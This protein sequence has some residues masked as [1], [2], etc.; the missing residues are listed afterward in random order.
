M[1]NIINKSM[2]SAAISTVIMLSMTSTYAATGYMSFLSTPVPV[3]TGD[4]ASYM[5]VGRDW[6]SSTINGGIASPNK[7]Q[8]STITTSKI[9][10]KL[11]L[12]FKIPDR[13]MVNTNPATATLSC[14]D[15]VIVQIRPTNTSQASTLRPG[16]G[17]TTGDIN[18][19]Y[20]YMVTIKN[21]SIINP[22]DLG[23][24]PTATNLPTLYLPN[25]SGSN[26]KSAATS[27]SATVT[28]NGPTLGSGDKYDFTLEIPLSEIGNPTSDIG[29]SLAI[30]NDLGHAH[31]NAG[32]TVEEITGTAFP[33]SMGMTS[34]SDPGI[35]CAG[36]AIILNDPIATGNW[37][38]PNTWGTAFV[39]PP[40]VADV[41]FDHTPNVN[42]SSAIRLGNCDADWSR[43]IPIPP[44]EDWVAWQQNPANRW[45]V[46]NPPSATPPPIGEKGPCSMS[47]WFNPKIT[48][49]NPGVMTK[50]R[51]LVMWAGAGIA[52]QQWY[53]A[54]LTAPVAVV[55][56]NTW[57]NFIWNALPKAAYTASSHPCLRVYALPEDLIPGA[58][59]P[60]VQNTT[61]GYED[62]INHIDTTAELAQMENAYNVPHGNSHMAQMNFSNIGPSGGCP[63][64]NSACF[65]LEAS[66]RNTNLMVAALNGW[67]SASE[68]LADN[69]MVESRD[70]IRLPVGDRLRGDVVLND[71]LQV[72]QPSAMMVFTSFGMAA[73]LGTKR[74]VYLEDMGTVA[75]G[76]SNEK[77]NMVLRD[78][79]IGLSNPEFVTKM[80]VAGKFVTITS[81]SRNLFVSFESKSPAGVRV[82]NFDRR[83][84]VEQTR[85]RFMPGQILEKRINLRPK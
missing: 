8:V 30:I 36:S 35:S 84:L 14:G 39:T 37:V 4:A 55:D 76:A 79:K 49:A 34:V 2:L 3:N 1:K 61:A 67:A 12:E 81:P 40:Q 54:G 22:A 73:P 41:A 20:R 63:S 60:G 44:S 74:Y 59:I 52:P 68:I 78:F 32:N 24:S 51:F 80:L 15:R 19:D 83:V 71:R 53:V 48:P 16:T 69:G 26:W 77:I 46:Y 25:A 65:P 38:N 13:T 47:I 10:G 21:K 11:K 23:N 9:G 57:V 42:L 62:F 58:A 85:E 7:M 66:Y 64:A 56:Q 43:I 18:K 5:Q 6:D 27:T 72:R 31:L 82:P 70:R 50:K 17:T 29:L 45:Y 75:F 28:T 33:S